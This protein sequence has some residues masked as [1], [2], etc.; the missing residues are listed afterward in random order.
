MV[1]ALI[2]CSFQLQ[3]QH[4]VYLGGQ[5]G[6]GIEYQSKTD[7]A[8]LVYSTNRFGHSTYGSTLRYELDDK[9]GFEI[10][11]LKEPLMKTVRLRGADFE[12]GFEAG[13]PTIS[14]LRFP[15]R[16]NVRAWKLNDRLALYVSGGASHLRYQ[17]EAG[18]TYSAGSGD[19][20]QDKISYR[21][22]FTVLDKYTWMLEGGT[23]LS[24][25]LTNKFNVDASVNYMGGFAD[26]TRT[27]VLYKAQ[28]RQEQQATVVSRGD[29]LSFNVG[30]R[31]R[32][33]E[34]R[35]RNE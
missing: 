17:F 19:F 6:L 11:L 22:D 24:Y 12:K 13:S 29:K 31:Y 34:L 35:K 7:P 20:E 8:D 26:L 10:G 9:Y 32:V 33:L 14:Y 28:G 18:P 5:F 4:R 25:K 2:V 21:S 30:I 15:I 27:D 16:L 23:S 3:A 1:S